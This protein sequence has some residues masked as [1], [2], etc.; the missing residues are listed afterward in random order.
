MLKLFKYFKKEDWFY[1]ALSIL[2][3]VGQVGLDLTLPD[4]MKEITTLVQTQGSQ[5]S[6]IFIAGG[7]MLICAFGSVILA[8]FVGFFAARLSAKFAMRLRHE[9]F[10]KVESFSMQIGRA[11]V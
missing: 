1:I 6:D 11:H 7:K 2:F 10:A 5:M 9:V 3:I 4:Y 8:V